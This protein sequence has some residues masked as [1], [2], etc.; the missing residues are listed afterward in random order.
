MISRRP[1]VTILLLLA[2]ALMWGVELL[3]HA[4]IDD[5]ALLRLGANLPMRVLDGRYW[6]FVSSMFLHGSWLH[7]LVNAF[8]LFQLG[9]LYEML[10]GSTRFTFI[11]FV[12]GIIASA[13]SSFMGHV[14]VGASGAVCGIAGALITSILR[15]QPHRQERWLRNV[16]IQLIVLLGV[17]L[18]I[19]SRFPVIDNS[20]HIGGLVAGLVL[21]LLPHNVQPPPPSTEV[22]DVRS[23]PYDDGSF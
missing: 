13:T 15:S 22:I 16:V 4:D 11:Y 17:N 19:A 2:I 7:V 21:G 3:Q 1:P 9:A 6:R 18:Y 20:A 5:R 23:Q 8:S 12:T 10:F 14:S